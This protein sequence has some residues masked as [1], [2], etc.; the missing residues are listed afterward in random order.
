MKNTTIKFQLE[1]REIDLTLTFSRLL[2]I[3]NNN[4][5]KYEE[6]MKAISNKNFDI[7]FDSLTVLYVAYLCG[8]DNLEDALSEDEFMDLCPMDLEIIGNTIAELLNTKK[9]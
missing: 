7:I 6:F 5:K 9:K 4:K 3:K 1:D 2:K 8:L